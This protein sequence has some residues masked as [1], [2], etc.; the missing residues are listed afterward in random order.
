MRTAV[1]IAI[2]CCAPPAIAAEAVYDCRLGE[3]PTAQQRIP[4]RVEGKVL[5]RMA[6]TDQFGGAIPET[7][8]EIIADNGDTVFAATLDWPPLTG[9]VILSRKTGVLKV[10]AISNERE[11]PDVI[12]QGK[13]EPQ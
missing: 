11:P 7:R 6:G 10:G 8:Y 2:L 4:F 5:R 13:C 1:T 9:L 3:D 12:V